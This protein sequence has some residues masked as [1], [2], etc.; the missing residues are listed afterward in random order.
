MES[1]ISVV[2]GLA[3][4]TA[5]P[6]LKAFISI[7]ALSPLFDPQW[8]SSGLIEKVVDLMRNWALSL[9]IE[10][11][12]CE[13]VRGEEHPP[14]LYMDVEGSLSTVLLYGLWTSSLQAPAGAKTPTPQCSPTTTFMAGEVRTTG[15]P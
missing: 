10:G 6:V 4:S 2:H 9:E 1:A 7:P 14:L 5:F 8:Q 12:R 11:L 3:E 13:V 15:T